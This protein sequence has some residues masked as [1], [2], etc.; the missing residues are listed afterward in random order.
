MGL[1]SDVIIPCAKRILPPSLPRSLPL[2]SPYPLCAS[3]GA[4]G[5]FS[6]L[7]LPSHLQNSPSLCPFAFFPLPSH[8]ST[9]LLFIH[10]HCGPLSSLFPPL[11]GFLPS[12]VAL[13]ASSARHGQRETVNV[14]HFIKGQRLPSDPNA[15]GLQL[16]ACTMER[17]PLAKGVPPSACLQHFRSVVVGPS[18]RRSPPRSPTRTWVSHEWRSPY[19]RTGVGA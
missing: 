12:M 11:K 2:P 8:T 4:A 9:H 19:R 7:L 13:E 10:P 16:S 6:L 15:G 14:A 17:F 18:K 5:V 3:A 1:V